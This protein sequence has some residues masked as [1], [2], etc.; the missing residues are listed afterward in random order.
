MVLRTILAADH[1][2]SGVE[3]SRATGIL[4]GTL[5]PILHRLERE[6]V[7][8]SASEDIDPSVVGRPARVLYSI[9]ALRVAATKRVI[10]TS[11]WGREPVVLGGIYGR[12]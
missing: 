12:I 9:K 8:E 2:V 10:E 1:G 3:I 4:S 11:R 6:G 5:Y 7:L